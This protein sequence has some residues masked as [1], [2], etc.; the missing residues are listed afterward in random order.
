MKLNLCTIRSIVICLILIFTYTTFAAGLKLKVGDKVP[1]FTINDPNGKPIHLS[2]LKGNVFMIDFWA[3]W[4]QPCRMANVELVPIYHKFNPHGF[5]IFSISL[6]SK[7]ELWV[8]AIKNDKLVWPYHGS[9]LKGFEANV[10][11][12][13]GV[14]ALPSTFLVDETG[15]II[16]VDF[17]EF[18]LEEK[19]TKIYFEQVNLYPTLVSNKIFFTNETKYQIEDASGRVLLKGKGK[20]VNVS[21]L[22]YGD[23]LVKFEKKTVQIT[24]LKSPQSATFYPVRADDKITISQQVHYEIYSQLGKLEKKG[25][26]T[27][28]DVS[29]LK[30]GLYYI[31]LDGEVSSFHKK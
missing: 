14:D 16:A 2:Q 31:S 1:D 10:A 12:L 27:V 21:S 22:S 24:K 3:S 28:V 11:K 25:N 30:P 29:H 7:K 4:C 26:E 19:L 6:D 5:E 23:Y 13:Y 20:E 15:S 17:D 8:E 9:E 18:D